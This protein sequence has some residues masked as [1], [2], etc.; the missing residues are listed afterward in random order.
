[1]EQKII[2]RSED[3]KYFTQIPNMIVNHSTA[4]EQSLYLIMKRISGE[5]GSCY[6]SL[7]FLAK[8]MGVHKT[9]VSNIMEKL[10]KR[11]WII[12]TKKTKV[13][14]GYTRTFIII[15]LW[16]R[17]IKEYKL[18]S[19]GAEMT[20]FCS[21]GGAVVDGGG[22]VVDGG[23]AQTDTTKN[24]NKIYN[25]KNASFNKYKEKRIRYFQGNQ[26]RFAQNKWWV[27]PEDGSVWK[28]FAGDLKD[29]YFN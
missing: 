20:T 23:G 16:P 11:K 29:T 4:Y 1:M 13:K 12:E 5:G 15:D 14:G 18:K 10:L 2:D 27:L 17:N 9:T 3:K 6:A 8:K 21:G 22:A 25:K 28:E 24:K 26:M 7:N 19:G